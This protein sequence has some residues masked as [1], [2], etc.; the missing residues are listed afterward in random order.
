VSGF[1]V[2]PDTNVLL[3]FLPIEQNAGTVKL[4]LGGL[5][6]DLKFRPLYGQTH[7]DS[8]IFRAQL[9]KIGT[10]AASPRRWWDHPV[11]VPAAATLSLA[12]PPVPPESKSGAQS[13]P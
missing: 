6:P 1:G 5:L 11:A 3:H 8:A 10:S 12:L 4:V 2:F 9:G 13:R 7:C